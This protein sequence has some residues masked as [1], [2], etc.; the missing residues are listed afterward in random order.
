MDGD[1]DKHQQNAYLRPA[2]CKTSEQSSRCELPRKHAVRELER[3]F[4]FVLCMLIKIVIASKNDEKIQVISKH[5]QHP[6]FRA[7]LEDMWPTVPLHVCNYFG[8]NPISVL[9]TTDCVSEAFYA[10]AALSKQEFIISMQSIS[11]EY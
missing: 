6:F 7:L 10:S 1:S 11:T 9:F 8:N 3:Q 4:R 5:R 2:A